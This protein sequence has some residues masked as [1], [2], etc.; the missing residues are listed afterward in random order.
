MALYNS[1][2]IYVVQKDYGATVVVKISSNRFHS[3]GL[4]CQQSLIATQGETNM[5]KIHSTSS[6]SEWSGRCG[7]QRLALRWPALES[8]IFL[9][10]CTTTEKSMKY[11]VWATCTGVH[12][13][14]MHHALYTVGANPTCVSQCQPV[15]KNEPL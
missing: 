6:K 8:T 1:N 7:K 12:H 2:A 14:N 15:G 11:F 5:Y 3:V 10:R 9:W 4:Y 13:A